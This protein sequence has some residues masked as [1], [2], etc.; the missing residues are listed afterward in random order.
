MCHDVLRS[1]IDVD[2]VV[3]VVRQ[4]H[5]GRVCFHD[6]DAEL[7]AGVT[8]HHIGGHT[9]GLQVV[10]VSTERGRVVLASD[11]THLW[12][13]IRTRNPLPIVADVTRMLDGYD[14]IESL[15]DGPDHII[16]GHDPLV[17][18][19][20]PCVDGRADFVRLDQQPTS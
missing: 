7:A 1:A 19:R 8:L 3:S 12:A 20:F 16:P 13:N 6:G 14:L 10:R 4:V 9:D 2:D 5:A 15:V 17:V 11:A 18:K